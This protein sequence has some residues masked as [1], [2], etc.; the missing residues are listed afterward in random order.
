MKLGREGAGG[1]S[2]GTPAGFRDPAD[3]QPRV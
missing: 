1:F 3:A 2:S